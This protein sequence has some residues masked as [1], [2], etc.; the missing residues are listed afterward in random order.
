M[1]RDLLLYRKSR[2]IDRAVRNFATQVL[3]PGTVAHTIYQDCV[4][5][6]ST[7]QPEAESVALEI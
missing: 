3:F 5:S 6:I 7:C 4:F 2:L 1:E